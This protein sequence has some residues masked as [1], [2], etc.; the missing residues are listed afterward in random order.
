M[1]NTVVADL[2]SDALDVLEKSSATTNVT[3]KVK[4]TLSR[5]KETLN[6]SLHFFNKKNTNMD[7][8]F[9]AHPLAVK[10]D[11]VSLGTRY[12]TTTRH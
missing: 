9:D 5:N 12:E 10:P 1:L 11:T 2:S 7:K 6:N 8:Y 3:E 4:M